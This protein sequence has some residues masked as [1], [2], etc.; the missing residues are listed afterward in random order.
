M[1]NLHNKPWIIT[2]DFNEGLADEDKFGGRR[3]DMNRSL[4][5]KDYLDACNV[6]D[7]GFSGPRFTWSNLRV[8]DSVIQE[9]LDRF[10]V[11]PMWCIMYTNA[12]VTHLTRGHSDHYPILLDCEPTTDVRLP[13]PFKFQSF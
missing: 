11:N 13:M 6:V 4:I 7:L 12:R 1:A 5:S 3:V 8:V 2:G 9:R 10:F